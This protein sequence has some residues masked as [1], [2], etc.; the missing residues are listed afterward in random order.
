M[1]SDANISSFCID[2]TQTS[3]SKV[4]AHWRKW[5]KIEARC[6]SARYVFSLSLPAH[7]KTSSLVPSSSSPHPFVIIDQLLGPSP[8]PLNC[9]ISMLR[10]SLTWSIYNSTHFLASWAEQTWF[11]EVKHHRLAYSI[12]LLRILLS[13]T[14]KRPR[15]RLILA[16]PRQ[17]VPSVR[18]GAK[19]DMLSCEPG[20]SIR[21]KQIEFPAFVTFTTITYGNSVPYQG[22]STIVKC[23]TFIVHPTLVPNH[24]IPSDTGI[25]V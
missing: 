14:T 8:H 18:S 17:P 15:T 3:L 20:I 22:N 7:A 21:Y 19:V 23:F 24:E 4:Q 5:R 1:Y 9:R 12:I 25:H 13:A 2:S 11:E 16:E 10:K 6:L